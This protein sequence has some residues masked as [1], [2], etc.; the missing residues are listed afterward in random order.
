MREAP[1]IQ[2][3]RRSVFLWRGSDTPQAEPDEK[4]GLNR[5]LIRTRQNRQLPE[6]S[7]GRRPSLIY[8]LDNNFCIADAFRQTMASSNKRAS[9]R[10]NGEGYAS[11]T[12]VQNRPSGARPSKT[13]WGRLLLLQ[14]PCTR[15]HSLHME[16]RSRWAAKNEVRFLQGVPHWQKSV[17]TKLQ[18]LDRT[19]D[20]TA[21]AN[22]IREVL[23]FSIEHGTCMRL[24][25]RRS[26]TDSL[27]I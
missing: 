26:E 13:W 24:Q 15:L 18:A 22:Q 7:N 14:Q 10:H 9:W 23:G 1:A 27:I 21:G 17:L 4:S 19:R 20:A 3:G 16:E 11:A 6:Q 2:E 8:N 12:D 25:T 5:N